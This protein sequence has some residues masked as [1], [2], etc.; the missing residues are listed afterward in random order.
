[1]EANINMFKQKLLIF[2][3]KRPSLNE[4]LK[5]A[6]YEETWNSNGPI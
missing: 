6:L 3:T 5:Y 1:M 4:L 2:M